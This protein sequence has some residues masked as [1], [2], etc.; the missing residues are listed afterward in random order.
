MNMHQR[1]EQPVASKVTK[2]AHSPALPCGQ[3]YTPVKRPP[4]AGGSQS[5]ATARSQACTS[6]TR[7]PIGGSQS[8]ATARS[9]ACTADGLSQ[10]FA[11]AAATNV[12]KVRIKIFDTFDSRLKSAGL[13][14]LASGAGFRLIKTDDHS[15]LAIF[16][17]A[18]PLR[19]AADIPDPV[20]RS[21]LEPATQMR[22]LRH[23]ATV[24]TH[25]QNLRLLNEDGK[26]IVRVFLRSYCSVPARG[27]T[28]DELS[29]Q[30]VC[31]RLWLEPVRGYRAAARRADRFLCSNGWSR[32]TLPVLPEL[33]DELKVAQPPYSPKL[34]LQLDRRATADDATRRILLRLVEIIRVNWDGVIRDIDTEFLH[35]FRV[36]IRRTRSALSQIKGVLPAGITAQYKR[37]FSDFGKLSNKLR[38]LDVYLL[39]ADS[40]R[41]M[42]P[43]QLACDLEP[44]FAYL[45]KERTRELRKVV[46]ALHSSQYTDM[47]NNWE[48]LLSN[49]CNTDESAINAELP[50][51][52]LASKRIYKKFMYILRFGAGITDA[53]PDATLHELR[54]D[55]K[56]LRYLLEFFVSLYPVEKTRQLIS[57]LK[58]LQDN[59]GRF[60]DL[61]VQEAELLTFVE[62]LPSN[63]PEQRRT[64]M[65]I[66]C[67]VEKLDLEKKAVRA[68]FASV[69]SVFAGAENRALYKTLFATGKNR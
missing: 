16:G 33:L 21:R 63:R 10:L 3:A 1:S 54:I 29:A 22:A 39:N 2:G 7:Q 52:G 47:M 69:F 9:Q 49:S 13:A 61:C 24:T 25:G 68:R 26:T 28:A 14:L 48:R 23:Y 42:L 59:L 56:K 66:G 40:F 20:G 58:R 31:T 62:K 51:V 41:D 44:L 19:F 67:L 57:Q 38:D 4:P 17:N 35:D 37:D 34:Q 8:P 15:T 18:S 45:A 12:R 30:I 6:V 53:T 27:N 46:R 55:C 32:A 60:N 64:I 36:A 50:V 5:S 43:E 65:A 11:D